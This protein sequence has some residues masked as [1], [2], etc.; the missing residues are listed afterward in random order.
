MTKLEAQVVAAA[1]VWHAVNVFKCRP[2]HEKHDK[3][4]RGAAIDLLKKQDDKMTV[5]HLAIADPAR[6]RRSRG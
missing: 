6:K 2:L 4:L 3:A 5:R 1:L